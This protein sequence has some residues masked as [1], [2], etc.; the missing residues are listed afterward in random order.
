MRNHTGPRDTSTSRAADQPRHSR[1][2]RR[3]LALTT[4][5]GFRSV[6]DT[7]DRK[8]LP[9]RVTV[10]D[11]QVVAAAAPPTPARKRAKP[12]KQT[13]QQQLA[14]ERAALSEQRAARRAQ[15]TRTRE[16]RLASETLIDYFDAATIL[17]RQE[18]TLRDWMRERR[19][20]ERELG[21]ALAK[22][23]PAPDD[24][25]GKSDRSP[26]WR[27]G[28]FRR[29][30]VQVGHL[31]PDDALTPLPPTRPGRPKGSGRKE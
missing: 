30:A 31:H 16:Q 28:D 3:P 7:S 2:G 24:Y 15:D 13:R 12:A 26:R 1:D 23:I 11:N 8:L 18:Q 4:T 14:E 9:G 19:V 27:E 5:R 6:A 10:K 21:Q 25:R 29:W 17:D 20:H 22:D